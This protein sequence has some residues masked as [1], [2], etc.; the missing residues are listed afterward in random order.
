[1]DLFDWRGHGLGCDCD[2]CLRARYVEDV[3][4]VILIGVCACAMLFWAYLKWA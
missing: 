2:R 4:S 1:M 3:R